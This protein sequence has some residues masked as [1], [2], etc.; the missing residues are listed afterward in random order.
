MIFNRTYK[1]KTNLSQED[2]RERLIGK[3]FEV[4]HL[5]FEVFDKGDILKIIP[6]AENVEGIKTLPITHLKM[7]KSSGNTT[8]TFKTKP[9]RIDAGG[10]YLISIFCIFLLLIS[11]GFFVLQPGKYE[12]PL[13]MAGISLLIFV[14]FWFRMETGYF[15]YVR[16]IKT[17]V[18]AQSQ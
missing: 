6:H 3:T 5:S 18:K 8:I 16:K 4:H 11:A 15:D 12:I 9:R 2:I 10:P 7:D 14:I 13:V 1:W 17:F